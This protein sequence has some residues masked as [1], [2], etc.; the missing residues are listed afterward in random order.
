MDLG[1]LLVSVDWYP[2]FDEI[3]ILPKPVH[4]LAQIGERH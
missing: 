3:P 2:D 1:R 4:K